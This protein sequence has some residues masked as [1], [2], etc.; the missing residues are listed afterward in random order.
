MQFTLFIIKHKVDHNY[1]TE[2][3]TRLHK[4]AEIET[5]FEFNCKLNLNYKLN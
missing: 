5:K 1:I 3:S 2:A 4:F